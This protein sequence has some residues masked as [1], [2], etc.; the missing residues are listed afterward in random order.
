MHTSIASYRSQNHERDKVR[1]LIPQYLRDGATNLISFMEEYY[2]YLNRDG[3][4]SYELAHIIDE[5]DID[6]TSE[7]YLDAIQ[8]EIAKIVPNSS[9]LDR[10]T[11]YKRIV[12]YYRIKGTPES[13]NVFFQMMF[14]YCGGCVL[15]RR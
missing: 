6:V 8:G 1:E 14:D 9:V 11:L 7:K 3:F 13:V 15:S 12:H 5:N 10:N 4:A 2:D